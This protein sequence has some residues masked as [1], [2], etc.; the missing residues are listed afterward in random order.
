MGHYISRPG[1]FLHASHVLID[2]GVWNTHTPEDV[3]E[4]DGEEFILMAAEPAVQQAFFF[5]ISKSY[6][7][8]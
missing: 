6:G 7:I 2:D 8:R 3:E 1:V 5:E 4:G